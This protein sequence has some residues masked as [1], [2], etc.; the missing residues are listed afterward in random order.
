[1]IA[2]AGTPPDIITKLNEAMVATLQEPEVAARIRAVGAEPS[3]MTSAEFGKFIANETKKWAA[4][5]AKA[6]IKQSN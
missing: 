3:P 2:P 1:M 4:V 6:G 5:I